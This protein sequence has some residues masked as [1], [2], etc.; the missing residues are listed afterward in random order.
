MSVFSSSRPTGHT[1]VPGPLP[2]SVLARGLR[3]VGDIHSDGIVKIEGR[4][5]GG[6]R[7]TPQLLVATGGIVVGDITAGEVVVSGRVEGDIVATGRIELQPGGEV[8]GNLTAPQV[9]VQEGGVVNGLL[10]AARPVT[11]VAL[12]PE[13]RKSA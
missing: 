4:L 3:V 1:P 12:V 10:R 13:L 7:G 6:I 9:V 5:E 11:G 8:R 2:L